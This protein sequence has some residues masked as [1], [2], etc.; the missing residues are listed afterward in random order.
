MNQH[1]DNHFVLPSRHLALVRLKRT[2]H[3]G[4][5]LSARLH[6]RR[7]IKA[8]NHALGKPGNLRVAGTHGIN[9]LLR[10]YDPALIEALTVIG[11]ASLLAKRGNRNARPQ[12]LYVTYPIT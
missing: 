7:N 4:R 6:T 10:R 1:V 3:S 12:L 11:N 9:D 8:I 5:Q 2:N